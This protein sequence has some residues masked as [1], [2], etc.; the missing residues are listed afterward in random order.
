MNERS[1]V[2]SRRPSWE[3]LSGT[4]DRVRAR[5][6]R[7]LARR[8]LESLGAHYRSVVSDLAFARTQGASEE[9]VSYLNSLAG[10]A[11][12]VLYATGSS[13]A[14]GVVSFLLRDYPVVFR[15]TWRYTLAAALIFVIGWAVAADIIYTIP[16][17][18]SALIPE[19]LA[20]SRSDKGP[21]VPFLE[22][23][24]PASI[25]SFIMTNN[26][27]EG[28]IAFAGGVTFGVVTVFTLFKNG[29]IIG[30]MLMIFFAAGNPVALLALLLPHGF[31][32]LVAI[33][34]CGGGGL[35]MGGALIAPG[36]LRRADAIRLA[37]G[38][39][40]RLFAGALPMF[41]VA[42]IIEGFITPSPIPAFGKLAF[43]GLTLVGLVAYL[44]FAG[45]SGSYE[46]RITSY[47]LPDG[48]RR[49]VRL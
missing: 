21:E 5:G 6:I 48:P 12:G 44:G 33:F 28:I 20:T 9:L 10:R 2:E 49:R 27:R 22:A 8:Q 25:S 41:V 26:I 1:F 7:S 46:L 29:L 13:R 15:A 30:G 35:M 3:E 40:L 36:N 23:P 43:S 16:E 47:E 11:H 4:L 39:A 14:R 17:A 31:I 24:D 42:A 34:V 45:R 37:A 32:E 18:R 19:K 38:K